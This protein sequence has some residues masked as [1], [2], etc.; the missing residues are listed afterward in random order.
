VATYEH[1][2]NCPS[3]GWFLL[4]DPCERREHR[5]VGNLGESPVGVHA[6]HDLSLF[7]RSADDV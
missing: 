7:S 5:G 1:S 6:H 4:R 3:R 2:S